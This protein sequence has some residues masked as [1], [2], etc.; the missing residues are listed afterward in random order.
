MDLK[1]MS[2][3]KCCEMVL[4]GNGGFM[5]MSEDIQDL[6]TNFGGNHY[7][8]SNLE[9]RMRQSDNIRSVKVPGKNY[10]KYSYVGAL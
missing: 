3:I 2:A 10:V 9:R 5:I 7:K 4:K 6:I 1:G 8:V